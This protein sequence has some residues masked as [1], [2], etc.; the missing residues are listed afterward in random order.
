MEFTVLSAQSVSVNDSWI[1]YFYIPIL[2][3]IINIFNNVPICFFWLTVSQEQNDVSCN[4]TIRFN[5]FVWEPKW[6]NQ[7]TLQ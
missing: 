7:L 1:V 6:K 5:A 4:M 3:D 2:N